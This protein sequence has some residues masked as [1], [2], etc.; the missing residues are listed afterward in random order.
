VRVLRAA[1]AVT[2]GV[3]GHRAGG[4]GTQLGVDADAAARRVGL[5]ARRLEAKPCGDRAAADRDE[6]RVAAHLHRLA[7]AAHR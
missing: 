2:R 3:D 5:H 6:Q 4:G 7:A 1:R